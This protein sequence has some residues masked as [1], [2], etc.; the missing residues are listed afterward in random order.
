VRW[1]EELIRDVR[2]GGRMLRMAPLISIAVVIT[3]AIGIGLDTGVFTVINGMWLRPRCE[4]QPETFA[5]LY[6]QYSLRGQPRDFGGLSSLAAYRALVSQSHFLD[7][8]AAWRTDGVVVEDDATRTLAMEVSCNFFSVYGLQHLRAGRLFRSDECDTGADAHVAIIAEEF[9]RDRFGSDPQ[10]LGKSIL[11]SHQRFT[12]VGITAL[13]FSGRVRGPG[14]WVPYTAQPLLTRDRDIF[15]SD[16]MPS[17]WLE[18]RLRHGATRPQLA[19]EATGIA[20]RLLNDDRDVKTSFVATNGSMIEDPNVRDVAFWIMLIVISGLTLLLIVSCATA[21]VLLLSRAA[22]RQREIAIRISLGAARARIL[23]QLLAENM[24]L[25]L[26]AGLIGIYIALEV[27]PVF[28][29]LLP[30]SMPHFPFTLDWHIFGYL[31]AVTFTASLLA[32]L[33]P[34]LECLRQD[35]WASL[36]GT[37][38][39]VRAGRMRWSLRDLLVV[40]QVSLSVVLMVASA[41][42]I[43]VELAILNAD[44]GVETEHVLQVPVQLPLDRYDVTATRD[45]YTALQQRL[46]ALPAVESIAT[47][48]ASPLAG[49]QEES[50]APSQFHLPTQAAEAGHSASVMQVSANYFSTLDLRLVRGESFRDVPSDAGTA[51]VSQAFAAAFWP[52]KDPLGQLIVGPDGQRLRI[53]GVVRDTRTQN[54]GHTDGPFIYLLRSQPARGDM[55]LVR[56]RGDSQAV[57]LAVNNAVRDLDP[58]MFV[59]TST[60]R[61]ILND[62]AKIFWTLGKML[63]FVALVAAGLALL[64]IYGVVGYSVTRRTREFG[65]RAALGASRRELMRLVVVSGSRP[66][67]AGTVLGALLAAAFSLAVVSTLRNA[68]LTISAHDPLTYMAVCVLLLIASTAAMLGHARRAAQVEPLVALREQ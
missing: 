2:Y 16:T 35:V 58:Q 66:V 15:R 39:S 40:T 57:Q 22:A 9:W 24:L 47:S 5:R 30:K 37:E 68:P 45:F 6:A 38:S 29:A 43:R 18:G 10:I 19:S 59:L 65:I 63:L 1:S 31:A 61:E 55:L 52:G 14:I 34:A 62:F 13:D 20:S 28:K 27:P 32:G 4:V 50:E 53:I 26:S 8:L 56:F 11:L 17:L 3:L 21:A 33:A 60:L 41:M 49:A 25:A 44:P 67:L 23:R 7:Q 42:F 64:G 12:V 46:A 48:S 36:K 51:V 54:P